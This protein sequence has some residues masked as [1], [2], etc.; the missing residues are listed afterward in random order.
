MKQITSPHNEIFKNLK[1]LVM[2]AKYRRQTGQSLLEGVHLCEGYLQQIGQPQLVI[3]TDLAA[4]NREVTKILEGVGSTRMVLLGEAN[5]RAISSVDNGI[6]IAF[7]IDTPS[8]DRPETIKSSTLLLEDI[9]DPGNL[10]TILR[11]AAAAGVKQVF[12]SSGSASAWSPKT[13]RS[14]MG[15]HF[16]LNIYENIDL[17]N[18]ITNSKVPVVATSLDAT[19]TIYEQD[20]SGPI[21]WIFGNEGAGV[22]EKL[23]SLKVEKLIIP[24]NPEVESL[25]VAASAAICLFEQLRQSSIKQSK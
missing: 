6:G 3:Y 7:V 8:P 14:G 17:V 4:E 23:L 13:L 20:L 12:L 24:Q 11:T 21:A 1:R 15:A 10:G 25:N 2:S 9:Q 18:L 22:S 19:K 16:T 5:F